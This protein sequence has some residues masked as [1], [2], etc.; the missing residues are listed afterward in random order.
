MILVTG[1]G[2]RQRIPVDLPRCPG[3][4]FVE[5]H[6]PGDHS[7]RQRSGEVR[8]R[9]TQVEGGVGRG[10]VSDQNRCAT[11][12]SA[13]SSSSATDTGQVHQSGV[14]LAEFDAATADLDL[15]V[16]PALE[17]QP[18]G[19]PPHQVAAAVGAVPAQ[20]RHRRILFGV[21]RR[22]EVAGQA[23]SAD[24]QFAD[25]AEFHRS[26]GAVD[27]NQIPAVQRQPDADRSGT[28]KSCAAGHHGGF[29]RPVGVPHLAAF[30]DQS[31]CQLGRTGLPTE[32]Q[33][34]DRLQGLGRPQR[35]ERRHRRHHGDVP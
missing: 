15:V 26:A 2:P 19:F 30:G 9:D 35:R 34:P 29:G 17:V 22:V 6:Q 24:H 31:L 32:N 16:G 28:V 8:A 18:V 12:G 14:D 4:Q 7:R 11:G 10:D 20:R 3:G 21:L 27:D 33:Q 25:P 23:Q 1:G 13:H 5:Q